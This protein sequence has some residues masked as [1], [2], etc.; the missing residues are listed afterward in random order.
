[1]VPSSPSWPHRGGTFEPAR[2]R[3]GAAAAS[4]I[5]LG[6][7]LYANSFSAPFILDDKPQIAGEEVIRPPWSARRLLAHNRPIVTASLALNYAA[8]GLA[9]RGYHALNVAAHIACAL[10]VYGFVRAMLRL[11]ALR[12]RYG[13][14]S[15]GLAFITAALFLAH[16][17]QT[18]SVTY[19]IQ[20]AE[21][22]AALAVLLALWIAAH[23][24][25]RPG[26]GL[27]AVL[28]LLAVAGACT[29]GLFS[30]E[31]AV[32]VPALF[33]L[34]DWCFIAA[35]R[36]GALLQRWPIYLTLLLAT[37]AA[38]GVRSWQITYG[39]E[40]VGGV[41][42]S[43]AAPPDVSAPSEPTAD[44]NEVVT[45][46]R[47][48]R[49]QFGVCVYYLRLIL[50]P[51]RLCFDCGYLGPWP[52]RSSILS[53]AVWTPAL[54]LAAGALAA[55]W[56]RPRYPLATF[57]VL[58]AALFLLPTSSILPLM[59]AYVEHRVYLPIA[60]VALLVV[61]AV[62]D[63]GAA[64]V[65]RGW[66]SASAARILGI[67]AAAA[68]IGTYGWLTVARNRLYVEPLR[69]WENSVAQAP[70][71]TRAL[72]NLGNEYARR[73]QPAQA[74]DCYQQ[75]IRLAPGPVY[76]IN[77]GRQYLKLG[78]SADA[79][80]ALEQARQLA[81]TWAIVQRNLS[82]AY[83]RVG[84]L[85]DSVAAAERA[86]RLEPLDALGFKLLGDAYRRVGRVDDAR[87]AYKQAER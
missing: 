34:Y 49:W 80:E 42:L 87:K 60:L 8:G 6:L 47:Y 32:V 7:L 54:L 38:V 50:W 58:G 53:D 15:N 70:H 59:D 30:K 56:I 61:A 23:A 39:G 45:P 10:L 79:V 33:A 40:L 76:Y 19:V 31:T 75:L 13:A 51:N 24:A 25:Q 18:E 72:F 37:A 48:L 86:T 63:G 28:R 5:V 44:G 35:G 21:I 1:M 57:C 85:A 78:R 81:P 77:L 2:W 65:R 83:A 14:A 20:R 55:W 71:S 74:I 52:V 17:I 12:A 68:V 11:P 16:P 66:L 84:R 62:Y 64:V 69:L 82:A 9:V 22:F 26:R 29:L 73:G 3:G 46:W 36:A 27:R 67:A 4:L 41:T 43:S